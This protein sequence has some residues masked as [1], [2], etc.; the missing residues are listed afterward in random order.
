MCSIIAHTKT[1]ARVRILLVF[2]S[3]H[4]GYANS[5]I[6]LYKQHCEVFFHTCIFILMNQLVFILLYKQPCEWMHVH[7]YVHLYTS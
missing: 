3:I 4:Y 7:L 2:H 5:F 6:L 1:H